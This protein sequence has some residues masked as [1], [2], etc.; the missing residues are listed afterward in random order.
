MKAS[1]DTESS[2]SKRTGWRRLLRYCA[3]AV[4]GLLVLGLIGFGTLVAINWSDEPLTPET[5]A[6]LTEPANPVPDAQNA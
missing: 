6:W 4:T 2:P 1:P 3:Y 5:R